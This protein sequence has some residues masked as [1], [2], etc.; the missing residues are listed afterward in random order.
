MPFKFKAPP[1]EGELRQGELLANVVMLRAVMTQ[2]PG[3][4]VQ[5][6][7]MSTLHPLVVVLHSD[8][9][10]LQDYNTRNSGDHKP[11]QLVPQVLLCD[12]FPSSEMRAPQFPGSRAVKMVTENRDERYHTLTFDADPDLHLP[13]SPIYL[14]FKRTIAIHTEDLYTALGSR[15]TQRVALIPPR[16]LHDLMHRFFGYLS[17][18]ATD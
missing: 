10:L 7:V 9:D 1:S 6:D 16:Y 8:C 15:T 2:D 14:D 12:S 11:G 17:R 3:T 5:H 4:E 18:V 13:E